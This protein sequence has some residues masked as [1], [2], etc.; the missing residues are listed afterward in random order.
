MATLF[1]DYHKS[2][3]KVSMPSIKITL[4]LEWGRNG[5][6]YFVSFVDKSRKMIICYSKK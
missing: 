3:M 1:T 6:G 5:L 2:H 4:M